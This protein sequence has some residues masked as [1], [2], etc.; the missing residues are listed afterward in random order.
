M[1]TPVA[2][3][4]ALACTVMSA[5]YVGAQTVVDAGTPSAALHVEAAPPPPVR[6]REER[7]PPALVPLYVSLIALQVAD[8]VTT[9]Q[10]VTH[11]AAHE[12]N[13]AMRPFAGNQAA[14]FAVKGTATAVTMYAVEKLWK[15]NRVAA[16]LTMV[17]VNAAYAM[18]V[19][20]NIRVMP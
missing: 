1:F 8:G 13:P 11:H 14:L 6:E 19:A 9:Y 20:N 4:F 7:R 18:V 10:A 2:T 16:V 15:K 5:E 17:G 12:V 3:C